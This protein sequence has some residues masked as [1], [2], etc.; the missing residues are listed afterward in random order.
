ML[1]VPPARD[2]PA[3]GFHCSAHLINIHAPFPLN[4]PPFLFAL[5]LSIYFEDNGNGH[6]FRLFAQPFCFFFA[7]S[8]ALH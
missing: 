3:R 8:V 6:S 7:W 1:V 5:L 2:I 4:S